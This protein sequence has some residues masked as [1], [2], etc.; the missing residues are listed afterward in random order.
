MGI[1][2]GAALGTILVGYLGQRIGWG[3]GSGLAGIGM[4]AG[5]VVFVLG[6]SALKG[7]G[8]APEPLSRPREWKLDA[9][10][11]GAAAVIWLLVQYTDV[12]QHLQ[13]VSGIRLLGYF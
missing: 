9:V 3:Y 12:S 10:G 4:L 8:E 6:K 13:P 5:L 7:A 2:V 1:N 11:V